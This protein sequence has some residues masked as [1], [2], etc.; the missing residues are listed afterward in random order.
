MQVVDD[1]REVDANGTVT[2]LNGSKAL[3]LF[4]VIRVVN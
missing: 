1:E 2:I 4:E 3:D